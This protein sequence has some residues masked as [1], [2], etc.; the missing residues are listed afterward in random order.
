MYRHLEPGRDEI[1]RRGRK[2]RYCYPEITGD[3]IDFRRSHNLPKFGQ[4]LEDDAEM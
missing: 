3:E 2:R 4:P 1:S